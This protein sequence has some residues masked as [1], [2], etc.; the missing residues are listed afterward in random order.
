MK[1]K[2]ILITTAAI[3][4]SISLFAQ[5]DATGETDLYDELKKIDKE[6]NKIYKKTLR[7]L[8]IDNRKIL[9]VQQRNWIKE[10]D[11][12]CNNNPE[13][14]VYENKIRLDCL[15]QETIKRTTELKKWKTN[16]K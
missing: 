10:R 9:K 15:I 13:G 5:V 14:G 11:V 12:K 3:L 7:T 2:L 6:L 1:K 4:T 16:K 8:P